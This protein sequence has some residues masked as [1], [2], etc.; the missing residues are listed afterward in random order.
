M[1]K[2]WRSENVPTLILWALIAAGFFLMGIASSSD[3]TSLSLSLLTAFFLV[4][5]ADFD[6]AAF[7]LG[8]WSVF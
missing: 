7:F 2:M 4:A 5:A 6:A 8:F 3:S 1:W